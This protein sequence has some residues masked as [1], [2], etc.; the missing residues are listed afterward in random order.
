M[1]SIDGL[2]GSKFLK[3]SVGENAKKKVHKWPLNSNHIF[4]FPR[5]HVP[6]ETTEMK[7]KLK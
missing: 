4:L 2:I 1:L 7:K 3:Y 6:N 5:V